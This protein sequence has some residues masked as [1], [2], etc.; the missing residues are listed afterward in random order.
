VVV[1]PLAAQHPP[2]PITCCCCLYPMQAKKKD[3]L[4][5]DMKQ[6]LRQEYYGLGGAENAVSLLLLLLF[7]SVRG[8]ERERSCTCSCNHTQLP[9]PPAHVADLAPNQTAP[10]Y[11]QQQQ[12]AL[13]NCKHTRSRNPVRP[14][15]CVARP[16]CLLL[17]VACSQAAKGGLLAAA[18][19]LTHTSST[20]R[21]S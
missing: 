21:T 3:N 10:P 2:L 12:R 18:G 13:H 16:P 1:T 20:E 14:P 19:T 8:L 6:R 17:F 5:K 7:W 9:P 15:P 11:L 4:S